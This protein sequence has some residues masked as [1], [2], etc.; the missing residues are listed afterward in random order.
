MK[1]YVMGLIFNAS[2]DKVLLVEKK[3]P[4]WQVGLW[5]GMGGKIEPDDKS[6]LAAMHREASEELGRPYDWE[7]CIT[8]VCPGGTVFVYRIIL[9]RVQQEMTFE[10]K[11]DEPLKVWSLNELP[12]NIA[13]DLKWI[14]PVCL[15]T[16]Q[17]P[18]IAHQTTLGDA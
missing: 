12:E 16:L 5:N 1:H 15:S 3:R 13:T 7:H 6:P 4:E 18:V 9:D 8:F 10:Q 2:R 14:I 11:E 17:F